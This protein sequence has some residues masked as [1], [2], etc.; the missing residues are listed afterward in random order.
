MNEYKINMNEYK[1]KYK[2]KP[3]LTDTTSFIGMVG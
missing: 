2:H 1:H 3:K